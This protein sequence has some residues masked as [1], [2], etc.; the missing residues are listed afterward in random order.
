MVTSPT[1]MRAVR[2]HPRQSRREGVRL[3]PPPS[4]SRARCRWSTCSPRP[5][6]S[7][8]DSTCRSSCTA[9][10]SCSPPGTAATRPWA[11]RAS[12][13]T[14]PGTARS[15]R[16]S[17]RAPRSTPAGSRW[18][19]STGS[20]RRPHRRGAGV[21]PARRARLR[22]HRVAG[23]RL[24]AQHLDRVTDAPRGVRLRRAPRRAVPVEGRG[25][26]G[27]VTLEAR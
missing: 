17:R 9:P 14:W 5:A 8:R 27:R 1:R 15:R 13:A 7:A 12:L 22:A 20:V 23:R 6:W 19:R 21:Q 16:C 18:A 2:G 26:S 11:P 25:A 3:H 24:P 10:A 4:R